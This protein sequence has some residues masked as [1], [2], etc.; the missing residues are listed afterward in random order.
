ME[1]I[2]KILLPWNVAWMFTIVT[3]PY[4][5][6]R[7]ASLIRWQP[8]V[9]TLFT[10]VRLLTA[11][12]LIILMLLAYKYGPLTIALAASG[13][14]LGPVIRHYFIRLLNRSRASKT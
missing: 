14:A 11:A 4:P 1:V 12:S 10:I 5:T 7:S 13:L 9:I 8:L 2:D 3:L 6:S